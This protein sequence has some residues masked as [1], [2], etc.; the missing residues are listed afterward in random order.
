MVPSRSDFTVNLSR[1]QLQVVL[2]FT[3]H[4]R[5]PADQRPPAEG[6]AAH[7]AAWAGMEAAVGP[8]A[9]HRV[10]GLAAPQLSGCE[11]VS[12]LSRPPTPGS[13]PSESL[14]SDRRANSASFEKNK[15]KETQPPL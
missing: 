2:Q 1:S 5:E 3:Q 13:V 4:G 9:G 12:D 10:R 6:P 11:S 15:K 7:G 14:P 8:A